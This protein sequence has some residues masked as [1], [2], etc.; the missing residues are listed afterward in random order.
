MYA[1][2]FL[3]VI[4]TSNLNEDVLELGTSNT[5]CNKHVKKYVP[6]DNISGVENLNSKQ[7]PERS[8]TNDTE[9]KETSF[10]KTSHDD[11]T[12]RG[13]PSIN[14]K[15]TPSLRKYKEEIFHSASFDKAEKNKAKKEVTVEKVP[16]GNNQEIVIKI[17]SDN[18]FNPYDGSSNNAD[19]V[20]FSLH[21]W[22]ILDRLSEL[23]VIEEENNVSKKIKSYEER[24]NKLENNLNR[25]SDN[26]D[27]NLSENRK[28]KSA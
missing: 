10:T 13:C 14:K 15:N 28:S 3:K 12:N 21:Q 8:I 22:K 5:L 6:Q 18:L 2:Y 19:K 16:I 9:C 1:M 27:W 17:E 20:S 23:A 25:L 4:Y 26:I 24:I 11:E 7:S